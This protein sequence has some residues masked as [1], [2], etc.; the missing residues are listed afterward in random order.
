MLFDSEMKS[1]STI[2]NEIEPFCC[3]WLR[4][5]IDEKHIGFGEVI[6]ADIKTLVPAQIKNAQRFHAF[7]GI[8]VWDYALKLAGWPNEIPVWTGSCPCQP[9]SVSGKRKG[10]DDPRHLWP[11]WYA[12][13]EQC[14][15]PV[16]FGEQ[17]ASPDGRYWFDAVSTDLET[18]G[19]AVAAADLCAAGVG[20]PN[21]R[22]RIFWVAYAN[23]S[24]SQRWKIHGDDTCKRRSRSRSMASG[25]WT[26]ADW[27]ECTDGRSRPV[28]PSTCPL[29]D[30]DPG[31]VGRLRAYGNAIN[32]EVAATFIRASMNAIFDVEEL[33]L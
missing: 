24:G 17:V 14:L 11:A 18:L 1:N 16:I 33:A 23:R 4:N 30:G 8:G 29:A 15:P 27:L 31:R 32:A 6:N 22:Q 19:Y 28:E 26:S 9:F 13:I 3:D 21:I 20:A 25:F 2:Y 7:A 10:A 5:L 12:L